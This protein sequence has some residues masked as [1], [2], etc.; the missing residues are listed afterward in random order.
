MSV[1]ECCIG[2]RKMDAEAAHQLMIESRRRSNGDSSNS[3]D[4]LR[5]IAGLCNAGEFDASLSDVP[6]TERK[7][8]GDATD[9]AILRF[10][11][12]LGA[13]SELRS[14]WKKHF[15]IAFNSKNK[16]MLRTLSLVERRGLA[17]ALSAQ[18]IL[19]WNENDL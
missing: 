12:C 5:A 19:D 13:V 7:I 15:E 6:L 17:T 9:Q 3:V 4:Q 16:F 1:T 11:E 18:E 10:S 2:K 8:I 14:L